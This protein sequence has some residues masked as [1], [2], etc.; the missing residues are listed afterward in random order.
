MHSFVTR[1]YT[2]PRRLCCCRCLPEYLPPCREPTTRSRHALLGRRCPWGQALCV[3]TRGQRPAGRIVRLSRRFTRTEAPQGAKPGPERR[4]CR[5]S[6]AC[7]Q[8]CY[9]V[10]LA[11]PKTWPTTNHHHDHLATYSDVVLETFPGL[12]PELHIPY[13]VSF[14]L[15]LFSVIILVIPLRLVPS[16]LLHRVASRN[17]SAGHVLHIRLQPAKP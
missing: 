5:R 2:Q 17:P 12:L 15:P 10:P 7:S 1:S 3:S 16:S 14:G 8:P 11:P 4:P 9:N 6:A 13:C